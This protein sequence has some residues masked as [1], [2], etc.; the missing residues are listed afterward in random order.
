M[1]LLFSSRASV[2]A[3]CLFFFSLYAKASPEGP[4]DFLLFHLGNSGFQIIF[5]LNT[6]EWVALERTVDLNNWQHIISV[7]TT[8]K[9][10]SLLDPDAIN[11]PHA[12]YRIK[13]PG[14]AVEDAQAK[15]LS[16]AQPDYE[17]QLTSFRSTP[18]H[19]LEA[20]VT[21]LAGEKQ[22][23]NV[24]GDGA[25]IQQP[26]PEDFPSITELF[27]ALG[28]AQKTGAWKVAV[29]YDEHRGHPL[30][31]TFERRAPDDLGLQFA[32]YWIRDLKF[33]GDASGVDQQRQR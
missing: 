9:V 16:E 28:K 21:V 13:Q 27:A 15:W 31:C 20:K 32:Q 3:F 6:K 5:R 10:S 25:P 1:S 12:A 26:N 23:S 19:V 8:N 11:H 14:T 24:M 30:W 33:V 7:S 2:V 29:S 18:P 4:P 17:L 22:L